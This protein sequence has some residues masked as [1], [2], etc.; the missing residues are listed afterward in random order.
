ML[1]GTKGKFRL[2]LLSGSFHVLE[3]EVLG[4]NQCEGGYLIV[5]IPTSSGYWKELRIKTWW[6][7]VF[8]KRMVFSLKKLRTVIIY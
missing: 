7:R 2:G 5:V 6:V 8:G 3:T 1:S 4:R